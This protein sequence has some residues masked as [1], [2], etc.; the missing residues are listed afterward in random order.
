MNFRSVGDLD[1]CIRHNLHKVPPNIDLVVGIPRSGI[2]PATI[3]ALT[4]N[5]ALTDLVGFLEGRVFK[6]M[7]FRAEFV[8]R[9]LP[10]DNFTHIL[11]V[12]DSVL[13]GGTM[14]EARAAI[15]GAGNKSRISYLAAYCD[16]PGCRAVDICLEMASLPRVFEWNLMNS[17]NLDLCDVDIDG[18]LCREPTEREND[19]GERYI[20]FL[21]SAEP[22]LLPTRPVQT[23]VT[24]R[25]E[26]YRKE[27]A[28]WL[29]RHN[30]SYQ[31]L[32][33]LDLPSKEARVKAGVHAIH[34]AEFY[35]RS[36]SKLFIESNH[37]QATE[38]CR[39]SG[40]PV[41]SFEK[42]ELVNPSFV[43]PLTIAQT[44][45][46]LGHKLATAFKHPQEIPKKIVNLTNRI[47]I[48]LQ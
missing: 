13:T 31:Q 36:I 47:R 6:K 34:K 26:K 21:K 32:I 25:L 16:I 29:S 33:M 28:E 11:I 27:T 37:F 5:I 1:K 19:D 7:R 41:L 2:L 12:D 14:K 46:S 9:E 44:G 3:I 45:R 24:S 42:M 4:L 8:K 17:G 20:R 22:R 43:S 40:K 30:V 35:R 38:I 39:L 23:L 10:V 15:E 18:V 48:R